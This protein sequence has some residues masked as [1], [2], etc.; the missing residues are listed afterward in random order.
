LIWGIKKYNNVQEQ[1]RF[2]L[3]QLQEERDRYARKEEERRQLEE[4]RQ[5]QAERERLAREEE[6]KRQQAANFT[7]NDVSFELIFVEGGT[8]TMGCTLEQGNDCQDREGPAHQV[9]VSNFYIG[10]YEVTQ[11]QWGAIMNNNPSKVKGDNLPVETVSW[12]D[13][14]EFLRILNTQIG[15]HY[16]LPTEAEWEFAARG[17]NK[18]L[19]Y[20]YSGSNNVD[21]VAWYSN[22]S[23]GGTRP[24]GTK[25]PNELGIYDMSGNVWEWCDD[26]FGNYPSTPQTDP[27]GDSS[28]T[29]RSDR[30]GSWYYDAEWCRV[31]ARSS[32][33][34]DGRGHSLGFRLAMSQIATDNGNIDNK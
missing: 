22:N 12:T 1:N 17:G 18:S 10:K 15:K 5:Q 19:G 34:P 7:I 24:V 27:K 20:K 11:A 14:Q 28:G 25:Q 4:E 30:G 16:R 13:V 32:Y 21:E 26:W 3:E 8:F 29:K 23:D 6:Q 33:A 2:A 31:S 9:T